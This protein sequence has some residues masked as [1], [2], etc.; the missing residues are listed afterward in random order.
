MYLRI[1]SEISHNM[2]QIDT[3]ATHS[4]WNK[5]FRNDVY[6]ILYIETCKHAIVLQSNEIGN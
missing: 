5:Q 4:M 2:K 3:S 1:V 6:P